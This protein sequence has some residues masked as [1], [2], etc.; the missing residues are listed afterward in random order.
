LNKRYIEELTA[1]NLLHEIG[2]KI[3]DI[4]K[5]NGSWTALDATENSTIPEDLKVEF[6]KNPQAFE[7]YNS[8]APSYRKNYLNW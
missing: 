8:F 7:N 5:L 4:G 6:S 1:S 2:S 3:I